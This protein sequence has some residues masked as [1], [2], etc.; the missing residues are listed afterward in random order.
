MKCSTCHHNNPQDAKFCMIC[1]KKLQRECSSCGAELPENAL[2]CM[3]C[4]KEIDPKDPPAESL[5]QP[6]VPDAEASSAN[7]NVL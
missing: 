6:I 3:K 2:F 7:C 4:G 1:G 5:Q